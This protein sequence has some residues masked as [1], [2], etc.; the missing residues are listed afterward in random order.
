MNFSD[1]VQANHPY[2][3]ISSGLLLRQ[4]R[5]LGAIGVQ[6]IF[7]TSADSSR[8]GFRLF[9]LPPL[10]ELNNSRKKMALTTL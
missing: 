5:W 4:P 8:A 3:Q 7:A 2:E 1:F 6:A 9:M 10:G